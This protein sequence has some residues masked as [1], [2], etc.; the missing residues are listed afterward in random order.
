L[1]SAVNSVPITG[2][3]V[4]QSPRGAPALP[5]RE[6]PPDSRWQRGSV[7]DALYLADEEHTA[8]AEWYRHLAEHGVPPMQQM[9]RELWTWRVDIEVANLSTAQGLEHV[10]L[11]VPRPGRRG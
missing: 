11:E 7:V 1:A 5:S 8:W 3:W 4:R 9:P 6:P 2:R 10:G